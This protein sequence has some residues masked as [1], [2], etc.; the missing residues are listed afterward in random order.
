MGAGRDAVYAASVKMTV[1]EMLI[2]LESSGA[3]VSQKAAAASATSK[4][5]ITRSQK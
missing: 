3:A 5:M 1:K 2:R 4:F